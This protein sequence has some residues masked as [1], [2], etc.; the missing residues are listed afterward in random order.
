MHT[1]TLPEPPSAY[2]AP[3]SPIELCYRFRVDSG[4]IHALEITA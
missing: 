1:L 3:G 4:L 2:F